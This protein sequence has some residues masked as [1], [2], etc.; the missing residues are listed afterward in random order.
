MLNL[1]PSYD[2]GNIS[3]RSDQI[4]REL[5]RSVMVKHPEGVSILAAAEEV[6]AAETLTIPSASRLFE[7]MRQEYAHIV[8]DADHHFAD[9]TLAALDVAD[10]ILLVTQLD[11]SALRSTQRTLGVF[12]RLGYTND[13]VSVVVNRRSDRDAISLPDAEKVLSRR[14][15][16]SI[17]NDYLSCSDSITQG[18]FLQRHAPASPICATLKAVASSLTGGDPF[19]S[20]T[21]NGTPERSRLSRLFGKR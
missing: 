8:V 12:S 18:Q 2:L 1:T 3:A 17:P 16:F 21:Q 13:K 14:V 20:P 10:R 5:V 7:V 19:A 6:D 11:V 4:D 15:D 9:P